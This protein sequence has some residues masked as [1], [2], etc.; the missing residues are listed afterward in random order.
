VIRRLVLGFLVAVAFCLPAALPAAAADAS[1]SPAAQADTPAPVPDA[2][3]QDRVSFGSNIHIAA[4]ETAR[5]VFCMGC[6]V[7]SEGTIARDLVVMGG[8]ADV[9]SVVGRD[10]FVMGGNVHLRPKATVGRDL[11]T[12]GGASTLDPGATVGR[13]KTAIGV[14]GSGGSFTPGQNF[15]GPDLG[16][17]FPGAL[18]VLLAALALAIF[19]RQLAVTASLAE[20]RPAAS[21]GLGCV[22]ILGGFAL[23]ILLAITV[24]LIPV[25]LLLA[26]GIVLAWIFGWAAIYL[27]VG[28]R[29][30][31]AADQRPQPFLAV[32]VGGAIF[33]VFS[34][35]PPVGILVGLIGG[36]IA[37][38][39]A[40]GSRFGTRTEQGDFFAWGNR[41]TYFTPATDMAP[42]PQSPSS[43][44]P[45]APTATQLPPQEPPEANT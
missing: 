3:A 33:A 9:Y 23:A 41:P 40:L 13:D 12:L 44:P 22:G 32:I 8:N 7:V 34:L 26:I 16:S 5:D 28:R 18:L 17:L 39:A 4:G 10:A 21:F 35:V 6:S 25:S 14:P 29:L 2:N 11:V 37:L 43:A 36:S 42:A 27:V 24:I 38:G 15:G 20:A 1:P 30:M 19:P 31:A 45:P